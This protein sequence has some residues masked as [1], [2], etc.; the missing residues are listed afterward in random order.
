M[1][2]DTAVPASAA[3]DHA[4]QRLG[5]FGLRR[6]EVGI[7]DVV[8]ESLLLFDVRPRIE[9]HTVAF[10]A[11]TPGAAGESIRRELSSLKNYS[12]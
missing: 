12:I 8:E 10:E 1:L 2:E 3:L 6:I 4:E 11:I 9:E 7:F 5:R